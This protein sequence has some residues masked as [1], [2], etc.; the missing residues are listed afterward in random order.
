MLKQLKLQNNATSFLSN[1]ILKKKNLKCNL[2]QKNLFSVTQAEQ[3]CKRDGGGGLKPLAKQ[4]YFFNYICYLK[5]LLKM[6]LLIGSQNEMGF[7]K[8]K[9]FAFLGKY[10]D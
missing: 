6:Q 3:F 2:Q 9:N 10:N 5:Y 4:N 1:V 8:K 7:S